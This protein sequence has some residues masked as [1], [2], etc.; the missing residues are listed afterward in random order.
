MVE[1]LGK[2]LE[3]AEATEA[4]LRAEVA[5]YKLATATADPVEALAAQSAQLAALQSR[6]VARATVVHVFKAPRWGA[7]TVV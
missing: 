7:L 1:D 6:Q 2:R 4:S 3:Q 5:S